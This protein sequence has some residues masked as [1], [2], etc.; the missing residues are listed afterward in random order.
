MSS[1]PTG[2]DVKR[3]THIS[4]VLTEDD[5]PDAVRVSDKLAHTLLARSWIPKSDDP[6]WRARRKHLARRVL[7]DQRALI[8]PVKSRLTNAQGVDATALAIEANAVKV[9]DLA[10]VDTKDRCAVALSADIPH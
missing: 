5:A 6:L 8:R 2:M 4:T 7:W 10:Q 3:L 1:V 9:G